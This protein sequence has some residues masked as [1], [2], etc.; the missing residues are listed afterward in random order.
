MGSVGVL[1]GVLL[2][3]LGSGPFAGGGLMVFGTVISV[4]GLVTVVGW[5]VLSGVEWAMREREARVDADQVP[6]ER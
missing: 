5:A 6:D 4:I 2:V 3:A 1:L